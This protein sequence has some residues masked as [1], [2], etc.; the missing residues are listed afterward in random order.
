[1]AAKK[2]K[3]N[4]KRKTGKSSG[5][6]SFFHFGWA[7]R[8]LLAVMVAGGG[9]LGA[10]RALWPQVEA[11]AL[12]EPAYWITAEELELSPQPAWIHHD[13]RPEIYQNLTLEKAVSL[14]DEDLAARL[15]DAASAH[16]WVADV[17]QVRK[18][19]PAS[20][21]IEV[22]YR[23]PVCMVRVP[24]GVRPVDA[25]GVV[26]PTVDF[27]PVEAARY[28]LLDGIDTTPAGPVGCPWGDP[29]VSQGA[30]VAARLVDDWPKLGL[31][32]IVPQQRKLLNPTAAQTFLLESREGSRIIWGKASGEA[33]DE[34]VSAAEKLKRL[35]RYFREHGRF[36]GPGGPQ[37]IDLR[38]P[39]GISV[40][41]LLDG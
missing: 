25:S 36:E 35:R 27:T 19:Y 9:A 16:P 6:G 14:M 33:N 29:N 4:K 22:T 18:R 20:V 28:P 5:A 15:F 39:E 41:P 1:M 21:Q 30:I 17:H 8:Y 38:P 40:M 2:R 32:A 10:W 26:L 11:A 3:T 24:G 7:L 31:W 12:A 37:R 13:I 23:R 34:E